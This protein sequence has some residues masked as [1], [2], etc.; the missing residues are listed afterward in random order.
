MSN[1]LNYVHESI[2]NLLLCQQKHK[3][4]VIKFVLSNKRWVI[5][6]FNRVV[7]YIYIYIYHQNLRLRLNLWKFKVFEFKGDIL[8]VPEY[9]GSSRPCRSP[10]QGS[11]RCPSEWKCVRRRL[12][13]WRPHRPTRPWRRCR[14]GMRTRT[15][16]SNPIRSCF[17]I[18]ST[19]FL[20]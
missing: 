2:I 7:K 4:T 15:P 12:R 10:R 17:R 5:Q 19:S 6:N 20:L 9:F 13:S 3:S 8:Y 16:A 18:A 14:W 1:L 11:G